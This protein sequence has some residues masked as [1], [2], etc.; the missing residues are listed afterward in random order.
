MRKLFVFLFAIGLVNL[1]FAQTM[2]IHT[3]AGVDAFNLANVDSITFSLSSTLPT[4]GLVAYYPFNGNANDESGNGHNG[5]VNGATITNDRF[6]SDNSAYRFDG[7]D[8]VILIPDASELNMTDALTISMWVMP[9]LSNQDDGAG[10]IC[11]GVGNGGE[12]YS[13]SIQIGTALKFYTW[14]S[15]TFYENQVFNWIDNTTLYNWRHLVVIFD[16]PNNCSKIYDNLAKIGFNNSFPSLL[17]TNDHDLSIGS[18]ERSSTSGYS[19]N[20]K[21]IIDDVRIYNRALSEEEITALYNSS[22]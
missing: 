9:E 3:N 11:K 6:G 10:I 2:Y 19:M 1:C 5:T 12:V 14:K 22:N 18:R 15:G 21:G 17:D 8:D 13:V 16:G 20:F 7:V 4:E